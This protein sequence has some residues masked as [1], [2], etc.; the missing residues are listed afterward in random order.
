MSTLFLVA[1]PLIECFSGNDSN[2]TNLW[3][4][5]YYC[6]AAYPPLQ[7]VT[8]AP[9]P[10]TNYTSATI[11]TYPIPT[12]NYTVTYTTS[13]ITAAGVSARTNIADGTRSVACRGYYDIQVSA[14]V[15]CSDSIDLT[16]IR[17]LLGWRHP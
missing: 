12:A 9:L 4:G 3:L 13:T 2:C 11:V 7:T 1:H 8:S 15:S 16:L 5:Y 6:V 17:L 14:L 10:T